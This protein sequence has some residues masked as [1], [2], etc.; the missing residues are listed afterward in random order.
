MFCLSNEKRQR[1]ASSLNYRHLL[2]Q[3]FQ[4]P[5]DINRINRLFGN[6]FHNELL[7]YISQLSRCFSLIYL[8]YAIIMIF[9]VKQNATAI[10]W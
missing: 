8:M 9:Y 5:Y 2:Q 10:N 4:H 3:H 7:Q 6:D 1:D